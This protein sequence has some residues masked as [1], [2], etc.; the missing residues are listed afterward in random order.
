MSMPKITCKHYGPAP[1]S[2]LLAFADGWPEARAAVDERVDRILEAE[3]DVLDRLLG[4]LRRCKRTRDLGA[5]VEG[6]D[7]ELR[8]SGER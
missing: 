4:L 5:W 8:R 2:I 6:L 3:P 7:R 1:T